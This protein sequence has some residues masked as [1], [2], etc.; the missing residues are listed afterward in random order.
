M[1]WGLSDKK[2]QF[3]IYALFLL[4]DGQWRREEQDF[5]NTICKE[6]EL[7]ESA[8]REIIT[9]CRGLGITEGDHSDEVIQEIDKALSGGFISGFSYD[10]C[11]QVETVWTLI[12]LGYADQEYSE[13]EKRVVQH[14]I[15]KWEK[16]QGRGYSYKY[17]RI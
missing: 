4:A 1:L 6:M 15:E 7:D 12:N 2:I 13:S 16:V 17:G 5:L 14:L 9:Y 3:K 8:K 11:L 10:S